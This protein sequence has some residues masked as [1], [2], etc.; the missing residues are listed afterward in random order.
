MSKDF[1]IVKLGGSQ[2]KISVGDII[3]VNK[4]HAEEGKTIKLE[5]VL[6]SR[7][8]SKTEIGNPTLKDT[9][10]EAKVI[11]HTRAKKVE[12][13]KYKAKARYRRKMGHR[14]DKTKIEIT[15]I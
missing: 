7:K 3:I 15:K 1:S 2:H 14:Q 10:V 13:F 9:V 6:L 8:G 12:I 11:E 4:L 5:E